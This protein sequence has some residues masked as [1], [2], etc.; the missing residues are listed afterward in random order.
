MY[1]PMYVIRP[2]YGYIDWKSFYY[3]IFQ[4]SGFGELEKHNLIKKFRI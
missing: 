1:V 4:N 3:V 2:F